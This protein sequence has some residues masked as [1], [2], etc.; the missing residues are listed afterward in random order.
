MIACDGMACWG[1]YKRTVQG[2]QS[3]SVVLIYFECVDRLGSPFECESLWN[4][5]LEFLSAVRASKLL[6]DE[7][8][9]LTGQ[10]RLEDILTINSDLTATTQLGSLEK[11]GYELEISN[12]AAETFPPGHHRYF[13]VSD[14]ET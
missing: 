7:R 12:P 8:S 14:F 4:L 9:K 1:D 2:S 6:D 13:A 5:S 11:S 3:N 10:T